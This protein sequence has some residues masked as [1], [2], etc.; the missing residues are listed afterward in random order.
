MK[1]INDHLIH[2]FTYTFPIIILFSISLAIDQNWTSLGRLPDWIFLLAIP[3]LTTAI[4]RS[5]AGSIVVLPGLVLG[6]LMNDAGLGFFG[7]ILGGLLMG[8][9]ALWLLSLKDVKHHIGRMVYRYVV[10]GGLS[11]LIGFLVMQYVVSYPILFLMKT[12]SN[13]VTNIDPTQTVLLVGVLAALTVVDL[14]GP[15]NKVAFTFV[16]EFYADGFYHITG[17]AIISV[18]IPPLSMLAIVLLYRKRVKHPGKQ[19]MRLL[20][21]GG[22]F[23]FTESAI[24]VV[25]NDP[26]RRLPVI[27]IGSVLA[28]TFAAYMGLSN[29]LMM[30]SLPGLF[31][32][33]NVVFYIISHLIGIG[34]IVLMIGLLG[35]KKELQQPQNEV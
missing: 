2:G 1:R 19:A 34:F 28:S 10:L 15:F 30:V 13:W 31:G 21:L 16:L 12:V 14:G 20:V 22:L 24:P 32:T 18:A 29:I 9:T 26:L 6:Y 11:F 8:Y 4:A 5:V 7:G 33:S 35:S 23:G 27:V 25:L 3:V 17:P